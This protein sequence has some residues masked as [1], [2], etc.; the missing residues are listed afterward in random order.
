M[1]LLSS[2]KHTF[3]TFISVAS[4]IKPT[5]ARKRIVDITVSKR[6]SR[7]VLTLSDKVSKCSFQT[8]AMITLIS[9]LDVKSYFSY[10]FFER[11]TENKSQYPTFF[12]QL[13]LKGLFK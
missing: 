7:S 13:Y 11:S 2:K 12:L 5:I 4:S 9:G 10:N 6:T 3:V 8:T 1:A